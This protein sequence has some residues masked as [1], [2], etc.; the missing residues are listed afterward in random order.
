MDVFLLILSYIGK[1][2]LSLFTAFILSICGGFLVSIFAE[3]LEYKS[4][5]IETT[6]KLY[7][8]ADKLAVVFVI[9]IGILSFV[10]NLTGIYLLYSMWRITMGFAVVLTVVGLVL[11][12]LN[13]ELK[14]KSFWIVF[15]S[16]LILY[17]IA[18][19][20]FNPFDVFP[21]Y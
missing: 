13:I 10:D 8:F 9:V 20:I 3:R 15:S 18:L 21:L 19:V 17:L 6:K 14:I 16:A 12:F 11:Y 4:E 1:I 7:V 5:H 2:L